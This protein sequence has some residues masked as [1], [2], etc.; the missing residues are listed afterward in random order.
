[1]PEGHTIHR[2]ARDLSTELGGT[3]VRASSPQGR[4]EQ[5][6]DIDEKRLERA[7]AIGKHLFLDFEGARVHV[8]LGLFGKFKKKRPLEQP[9]AAVRLRLVNERAT[10]DLSG[11]TACHV[12][13][14]DQLATLTARLGADPLAL[15]K[16]SAGTWKRVHASSRSMGALLL[17][18]SIFAGIGN[19]YRAELLFLVGIH[20]E[21]PGRVVTKAQFEQLWRLAK[22]LLLRGVELN[23]I[24]T[25]P[26]TGKTR[27]ERL[28]VYKQR[29]CRVCSTPISHG[30]LAARTIYFCPT[31]QRLAS[32]RAPS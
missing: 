32:G 16:R 26:G 31:C 20:P 24:V 25:V 1:M 3:V 21:T 29:Q 23:R 15:G 2:L 14:D 7:F 11:P 27:R 13:D 6:A 19:V 10:W 12:I 18:Q 4:F 17:D 30:M 9:G 28:F 22:Q 8:H 5:A